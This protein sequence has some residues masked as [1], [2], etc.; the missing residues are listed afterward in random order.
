VGDVSVNGVSL[1]RGDGGAIERES[2]VSIAGGREPSEVL[3]FDLA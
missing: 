2:S 3:V 1:A